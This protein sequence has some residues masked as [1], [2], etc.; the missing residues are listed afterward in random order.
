MNISE[1]QVIAFGARPTAPERP[2]NKLGAV[3]LDNS[4]PRVELLSRLALEGCA[5][6]LAFGA[7]KYAA[8]NWREGMEWRRVIGALLRHAL[9]FSDGKDFDEDSGLPV[10]DHVLCC[11]MFLSEYQKKGLGVDNR[12]KSGVEK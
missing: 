9:E 3:K 5:Q 11:A 8:D 4:K 12:H 2:A 10:I 6:V 1:D 7:E